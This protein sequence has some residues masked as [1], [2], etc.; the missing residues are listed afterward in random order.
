M[1]MAAGGLAKQV[2]RAL[3]AI[4]MTNFSLNIPVSVPE[5]LTFLE[6]RAY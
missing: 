2:V 4:I 1:T 5:A 3:A 6:M